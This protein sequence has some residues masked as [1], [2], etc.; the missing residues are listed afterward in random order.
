MANEFARPEDIEFALKPDGRI[1][2]VGLSSKPARDSNHVA[3]YLL[4]H[5]YEIVPVN[6]NEE[7]VLG[8]ECY[9]DL[10]S[11]PGPIHMVDIF[12]RSDAAG[13]VVDQA[14]A[15]GAAAVW[16]Q[17]GVIDREAAQ[18]AR[19]AGLRVIMDRCTKVEH[20]DRMV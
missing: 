9:P 3:R 2:I 5:G 14:I 6:P 4:K 17:F 7:E 19:E 15:V 8:L 10:A 16:L 18:R 1:A 13:E 12:R 20:F 11:V